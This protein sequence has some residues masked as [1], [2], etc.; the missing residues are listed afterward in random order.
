M[1]S[2]CYFDLHFLDFMLFLIDGMM[3][4]DFYMNLTSIN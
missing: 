4:Y 2:Q 1:K 3:A